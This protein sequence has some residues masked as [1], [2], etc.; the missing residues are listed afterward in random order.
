VAITELVSASFLPRVQAQLEEFR[1]R[2]EL[3]NRSQP[4]FFSPTPTLPVLQAPGPQ[5]APFTQVLFAL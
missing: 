2:A 4:S 3:I 5:P 1:A